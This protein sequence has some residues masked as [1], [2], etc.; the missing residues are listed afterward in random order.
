M[1]AQIHLSFTVHIISEDTRETRFDTYMNI[2]ILQMEEV[3]DIYRQYAKFPEVG[4]A[5]IG[6]GDTVGHVTVHTEW[7]Q[8]DLERSEKVKFSQDYVVHL[9]QVFSTPC[10]EVSTE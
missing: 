10:H 7:S 9:D 4:G 8:R 1:C 2:L 5:T 3:T 6:N